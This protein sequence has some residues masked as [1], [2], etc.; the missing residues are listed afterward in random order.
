MTSQFF[1]GSN[2][3][4]NLN[5]NLHEIC[6]QQTLTNLNVVVNQMQQKTTPFC[7]Y[8]VH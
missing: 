4:Q 1:D 5:Q 7:S 3:K 2:Q 8:A 6:M